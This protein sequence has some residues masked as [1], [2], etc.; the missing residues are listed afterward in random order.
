MSGGSA[1]TCKKKEQPTSCSF[2]LFLQCFSCCY[3]R[4]TKYTASTRNSTATK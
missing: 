1:V 4:N 2:C 3:F